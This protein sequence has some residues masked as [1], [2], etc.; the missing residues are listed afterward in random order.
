MESVLG[1]TYAFCD[2][3]GISKLEMEEQYVNLKK[4]CQQT[5]IINNHHSEVDCFNDV[6]DWLLEELDSRF[7]KK[8]SKLLMCLADLRQK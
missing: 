8:N 2:K 1:E 7:N 5:G 4:P 6:I 3:H